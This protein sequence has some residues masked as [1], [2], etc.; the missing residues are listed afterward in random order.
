MALHL[1]KR[2]QGVAEMTLFVLVAFY[3]IL[4]R[5]MTIACAGSRTV[6]H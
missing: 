5:L 6:V 4:S 1:L 2:L 3:G